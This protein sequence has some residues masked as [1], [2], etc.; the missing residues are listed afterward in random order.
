M[1]DIRRAVRGSWH[2]SD[3]RPPDRGLSERTKAPANTFQA[4]AISYIPVTEK[5]VP[6][7]WGW[8]RARQTHA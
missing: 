1:T 5:R 7:V 8:V 2:V 3:E 6:E 4:D